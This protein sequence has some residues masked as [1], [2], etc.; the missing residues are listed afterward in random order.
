MCCWGF[1]TGFPGVDRPGEVIRN[2]ASKKICSLSTQS[3][4]KVEGGVCAVRQ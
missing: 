3:P 1:F 2:V 4:L